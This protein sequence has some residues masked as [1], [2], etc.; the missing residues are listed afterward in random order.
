MATVFVL[1]IL[2]AP[3]IHATSRNSRVYGLRSSLQAMKWECPLFPFSTRPSE[4]RAA[5]QV[6]AQPPAI[7]SIRR[8]IT[9][10]LDVSIEGFAEQNA[11]R[12]AEHLV[13]ELVQ[14][15]LDSLP[16]EGGTISL[17]ITASGG[18]TLVRCSDNGCGIDDLLLIRTVFWTSKK[19]SHL[20]RGRM[21]RGFK[22]MLCLA[23]E[24]RVKSKG[25]ELLFHKENG[26]A[27]TSLRKLADTECPR[28]GT[29]V[30]MLMPWSGEVTI[31]RLEAYFLP[32]LLPEPVAF[33]INGR[34]VPPRAVEHTVSATL[35][36]EAFLEGRWQKPQR[37]TSIELVRCSNGTDALIHEMG[38]PICPVE[39]DQPYH[40][41]V[42]Q[43][44]PMNPNRD[45]VMSGYPAKVKRACLEVLLPMMDS[46]QAQAS[47]V[48]DAAV[49]LPSDLQK[50]ALAKAFGESLARSVPSFGKYSSDEDAREESFIVLDTRQLQGGF[51][52][53]V[54]SHV[55]T[56]K[57]VVESIRRDELERAARQQ[58]DLDGAEQDH[59]EA[60][61][62]AGGKER[63]QMVLDF[64]RW[65]CQ[66]ILDRL[67]EPTV[68]TAR[69]AI[70]GG[71]TLATWSHVA[72]QL[73]LGLDHLDLWNDPFGQDLI[74]TLLHEVAHQRAAHHGIGFTQSIEKCAA[75]ACRLV[76]DESE[77]IRSVLASLSPR[78]AD[79]EVR[80]SK[81][82]RWK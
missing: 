64:A 21:G 9:G 29:L 3:A 25:H 34:T 49:T 24:A 56:S 53:L 40:V 55:P 23:L 61:R 38:I 57:Q 16:A 59:Q 44:V 66:G 42:L 22:E 46:E 48:G 54:K 39:W 77:H 68:C 65:F 81:W 17:D 32:F 60:I 82:F 33:V 74:E 20:R 30:E 45:A 63:V 27:Q 78:E 79:Q 10:W 47:W 6:L 72:S 50:A 12:P 18:N 8:M 4:S 58:V 75:H 71:N 80:A 11:A 26:E 14:N 35:T 31:P 36:T 19:D 51:R 1:L 2:Q 67:G 41:N 76:L 5:L 52:D 69:A 70:L 43:R 37:K 73:T 28:A 7:R 62:R 15:A 13:K